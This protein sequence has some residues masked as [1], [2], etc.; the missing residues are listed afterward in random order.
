MLKVVVKPVP[1]AKI[2]SGGLVSVV[3]IV[4]MGRKVDVASTEMTVAV[5]ATMFRKV[6]RLFA[7]V[8][9]AV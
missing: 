6:V 5:A 7:T 9:V 2:V 3:G 8:S 4:V 1:G